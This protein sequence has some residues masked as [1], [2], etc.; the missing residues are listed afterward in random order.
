MTARY[1]RGH[2][3]F[4]ECKLLE[5]FDERIPINTDEAAAL[6][7]TLLTPKA[8]K[9]FIT[10]LVQAAVIEEGTAQMRGEEGEVM[11]RAAL[12]TLATIASSHCRCLVSEG[13]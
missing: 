8:L 12:R 11:G 2:V 10:P 9:S 1:L 5:L 13:C 3:L 4:D 6:E 7:K